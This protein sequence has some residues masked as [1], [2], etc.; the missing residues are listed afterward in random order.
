M[1]D[2]DRSFR[3]A[4][5]ISPEHSPGAGDGRDGSGS[6]LTRR[7]LMTYGGQGLALVGAGSLLAAC[8]S[9]SSG[10]GTAAGGSSTIASAGK[11]VKGGKLNVGMIS[12]GSAET[13]DPGIAIT[14]GDI[15]R[16]YQLYDF[17]FQPGPGNEFHVLEPRLATSA[18]PN[19]DATAWTFKLREGVEWHDGKPFTADD[20]VWSIKSWS[21][22]ENYAGAYAAPFIDF[23]GVRKLDKYTVEVPMT[24]PAAQF[25]TITTLWNLAII[26]NGATPTTLAQKP[27]GT[28]PFKFVSFKPGSQS[29]FARNDNYWEG[30]GK[31][32]VDELI[33]NTTFQDETSRYNA[34]LGGQIDVS[35]LFPANYA[36]QQQSSQQVNV[37][38]SPSGQAYTFCMRVDKGPFTDVRVRQA[39]KLLTDRQALI[40]GVFPGYAQVGN[41]LEGRFT[42][43]FASDLKAEYDVEKAKSLLKAAGQENLTVT[44]P[45][46]NAAPGFVESAT[47]FAQQAAKAGVTVNVEQTS[48]ETYY[49]TS[50][51]FLS[52]PFG[53]SNGNSWPSMTV[54]AATLF[55]EGAAFEESGWSQQ[56][57]G[58]N[59]AL[60]KKAMGELDPSKAQDLWHEVQTEWFEKDGHIVWCNLDF[61]D[62]AG[63]SVSGLSSGIANPLNNFRLLDGWKAS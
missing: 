21:S 61:I 58:G 18:E 9:S 11:P 35:P 19:K 14:Y 45:T 7:Q 38:S 31:P 56:P 28:G 26:Q 63:K 39:M 25:P 46:A 30:N 10:G 13:V 20:V 40:D 3:H 49:T 44:L 55:V 52:R 34:L 17:L 8:G 54:T 2:E 42:Q 1:M 5:S 62:A 50:G 57:G 22:P 6:H 32:Y 51:G 43:Y 60:I 33:V 27:V 16:V 37:L 41:D 24:K 4:K 36:R 53:Q 15:L 12:A 23:K 29:V 59:Q 48:A 47:L